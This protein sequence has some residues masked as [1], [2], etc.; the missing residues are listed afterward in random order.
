MISTF[1]KLYKFNVVVEENLNDQGLYRLN[2]NFSGDED[3]YNRLI[4]IAQTDSVLL[5]CRTLPFLMKV[6]HQEKYFFYLEQQTNKKSK[7]VQWSM[8][9]ILRRD[10]EL[11]FF[12]NKEDALE[13][14][15]ALLFHLNLFA[16]EEA[17]KYQK[18]QNI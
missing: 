14:Q 7:H 13:V 3:F 2:L 17:L 11:L 16:R 8:E 10:K 9:N 4:S 5:T 12:N 1:P 6:L 15:K 18:L